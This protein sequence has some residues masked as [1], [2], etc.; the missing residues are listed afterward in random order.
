VVAALDLAAGQ[1]AL[2][3]GGVWQVRGSSSRISLK[4]MGLAE[5]KQT[6]K[7]EQ[8]L[9]DVTT[10]LLPAVARWRWPLRLELEPQAGESLALAQQQAP[11]TGALVGEAGLRPCTHG[12]SGWEWFARLDL[13]PVIT[14]VAV[15]D[16]LLGH[17]VSTHT[18]LPALSL[19]DWS[20]G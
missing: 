20:M 13:E 11:V 9:P 1:V 10:V 15:S 7:R 17:S 12:R 4:T 16:P 18:L 5:L 3:L 19:V 6:F 8:A 2:E 14:R